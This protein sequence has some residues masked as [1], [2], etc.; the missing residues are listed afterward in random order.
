MP[1]GDH[2]FVFIH[3]DQEGVNID[4]VPEDRE[5]GGQGI[6]YVFGFSTEPQNS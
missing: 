1:A 2:S 4:F 6:N 3:Y 5:L